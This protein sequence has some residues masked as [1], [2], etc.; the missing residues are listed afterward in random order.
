MKL[1]IG[2]CQLA[3]SD[4]PTRNAERVVNL[5]DDAAEA[6]AR[7]AHFP[8]ACLSGYVPSDRASNEDIDW[9][10]L[11]TA[12]ERIA[13]HAASRNVW[14]ILGSAH[15]LTEPNKPHN[16]LYIIS[17]AGK[18]VDRYDKRFL[19]G[20]PSEDSEELAAY[21]PGNHPTVFR[22][23]GVRCGAL[24]CYEYRFPELYRE[25]K[26]HGVDLVFHSYNAAHMSEAAIDDSSSRIGPEFIPLNQGSTYPA[27]V[28]PASMI[29]AAAANHV[30][31]S[32]AN[33]CTPISCWESFVVRADGI[34]VGRSPRHTPHC[35]V[36]TIDV[37][38]DLYDGAHVWRDRAM[39]G[40][41]HSGTLVDDPRSD[42][43]RAL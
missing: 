15:R 32:C 42:D 36:T 2:T 3:P 1:K 4:N 6:G 5:I 29:A 12:I 10:T 37:S 8:E 26:E 9:G 27:N 28:M 43:R 11:R 18:I 35:L 33:S 31:I 20:A 39:Q 21:T 7:V 41:L 19:S 16:S 14:V 40:V 17:D 25:Y 34:V 23:D 22:I 38:A 13:A 24:V 30:W